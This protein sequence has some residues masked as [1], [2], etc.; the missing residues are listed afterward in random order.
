M[1][2]ES[3]LPSPSASP[4]KKKRKKTG[5]RKKTVKENKL[6]WRLTLRLNACLDAFIIS[7]HGNLA[8]THKD[9]DQI[10]FFREHGL[11]DDLR[12]ALEGATLCVTLPRR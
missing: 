3:S 8:F 6:L 1:S 2:F 7:R 4:V 9:A 11:D 10:A 12:V 5:K